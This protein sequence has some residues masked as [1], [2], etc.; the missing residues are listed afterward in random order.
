MSISFWHAEMLSRQQWFTTWH[1]GQEFFSL[2]GLSLLQKGECV[3]KV[4]SIIPVV[5]GD[6]AVPCRPEMDKDTNVIRFLAFCA[7]VG[8]A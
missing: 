2:L 8:P 7:Q 6:S 4:A 1:S 5:P 3:Q